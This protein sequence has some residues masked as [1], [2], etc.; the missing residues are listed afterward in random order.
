MTPRALYSV[1]V[2]A[3]TLVN[4]ANGVVNGAV[5]V[6]FRVEI[7]VRSPAI[8]DDRSAGFDPSIYNSHQSVGGSVRNQRGGGWGRKRENIGPELHDQEVVR[9]AL[10][11]IDSVLRYFCSTFVSLI[12]FK[13]VGKL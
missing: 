13:E 4:E 9:E 5:G 6:T 11:N 1:C 7:P 12:F 10:Y 8:T 2:G 3:S